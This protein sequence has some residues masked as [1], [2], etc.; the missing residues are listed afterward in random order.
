MTLDIRVIAIA[1][2]ALGAGF[3]LLKFGQAI[4]K[5]LLALGGLIA[6]GI[7]GLALLEQAR[8]TRAVATTASIA[9]TGQAATSAT[10]SAAIVFIIILLLAGA[11]AAAYSYLRRR[12]QPGRWAPGPNA[13]WQV[14][15]QAGTSALPAPPAYPLGAWPYP[16]AAPYL[17]AQSVTPYPPYL[18]YPPGY[19]PGP[20]SVA[21]P[22]WPPAVPDEPQEEEDDDPLALPWW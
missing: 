15:P 13:Y 17:P 7:I 3:L 8:A 16:P 14:G 4:A 18:A 9:A 19:P 22:T 1:V 6:A 2:L 5:F 21:Y 12:R 20:W 11:A 10:L